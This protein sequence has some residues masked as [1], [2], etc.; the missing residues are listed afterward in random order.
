MPKS[1]CTKVVKSQFS[2]NIKQVTMYM[3]IQYVYSKRFFLLHV[4]PPILI[5]P[6]ALNV[7]TSR[8]AGL[9]ARVLKRRES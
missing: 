4:L 9:E 6:L 2:L 1:I 8:R 3:Y 5:S 7:H